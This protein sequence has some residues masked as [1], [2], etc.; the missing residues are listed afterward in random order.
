MSSD[1]SASRSSGCSAG[2]DGELSS[3]GAG[4]QTSSTVPSGVTVA[5]PVP[6]APSE[7][8]SAVGSVMARSL[9]GCARAASD[10]TG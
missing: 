8:V 3:A 2:A 4:Y 6:Y 9:S 10:P 7:M 5:R 1:R